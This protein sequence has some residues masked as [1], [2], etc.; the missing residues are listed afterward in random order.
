MSADGVPHRLFGV[1]GS[2]VE[3]IALDDTTGR[4]GVLCGADAELSRAFGTLETRINGT[5]NVYDA[6]EQN[7]FLCEEC[8]L[9]YLDHIG[10]PRSREAA[11]DKVGREVF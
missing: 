6:I 5:E 7:S 9:R 8:A 4:S 10:L 1:E 2:P 11:N 3:H